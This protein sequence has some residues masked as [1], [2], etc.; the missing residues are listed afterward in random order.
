MLLNIVDVDDVDRAVF[1]ALLIVPG[2][3]VMFE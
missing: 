2:R 1:D 3:S